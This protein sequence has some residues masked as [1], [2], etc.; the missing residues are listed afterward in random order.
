V[1]RQQIYLIFRRKHYK[2]LI[3]QGSV[4]IIVTSNVELYLTHLPKMSVLLLPRE[5][6]PIRNSSGLPFVRGFPFRGSSRQ[7]PSLCSVFH[8][9]ASP[10]QYFHHVV[11][12]DPSWTVPFPTPYGTQFSYVWHGDRSSSV[13][14]T[15]QYHIIS[16][17]SLLCFIVFL[18][19]HLLWLT[20]SGLYAEVFLSIL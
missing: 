11:T 1:T 15:C 9:Q 7:V 5:N 8:R 16:F 3:G 12:P 17:L 18:L 6:L 14:Q 2:I 13:R 20:R 19:Q 10:I 4:E